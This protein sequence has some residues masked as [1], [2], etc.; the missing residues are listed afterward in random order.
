MTTTTPTLTYDVSWNVCVQTRASMKVEAPA[1]LSGE[2][3]KTFIREE[4]SADFEIDTDFEYDDGF[5]DLDFN[6]DFE[7]AE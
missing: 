3:L 4:C 5:T 6:F 1:G 7:C 2:E